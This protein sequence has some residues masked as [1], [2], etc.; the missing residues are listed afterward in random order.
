MMGYCSVDRTSGAAGRVD[1][2]SLVE[3]V[4]A[5]ALLAVVMILLASMSLAVSRRGYANGLTT[6]RNLALAQQAGRISAM[7]FTDVSALTTGTTAM[8]IGDFSFNRRLTVT[9][10]GGWRYTIKVVIAPV[11]SEFKPDSITIDRTRP[12]SGTPLCTIC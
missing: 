10:V 5:M 8:L 9:A 7:P 11:A 2:F 4:V 1:G 6:K 3:V 12:P